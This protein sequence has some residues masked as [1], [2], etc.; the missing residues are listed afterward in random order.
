LS[1]GT[2]API[3]FGNRIVNEGQ[4]KNLRY[5]LLAQPKKIE[6]MV[7]QP[8]DL[9]EHLSLQPILQIPAQFS[10]YIPM[11]LL[12]GFRK[13]EFSHESLLWSTGEQHLLWQSLGDHD[14]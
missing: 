11:E 4:L 1:S 12:I 8:M 2:D 6:E 9:F 10:N 3:K 7:I 13:N 14:Q 5:L